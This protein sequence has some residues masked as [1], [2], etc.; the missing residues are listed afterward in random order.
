MNT[1]GSIFSTFSDEEINLVIQIS[2]VTAVVVCQFLLYLM[3]SMYPSGQSSPSALTPVNEVRNEEVPPLPTKTASTPLTSRSAP[4]TKKPR[5][6]RRC[7][8][9]DW[10][11]L[12]T[13]RIMWLPTDNNL[14]HK[15]SID[16]ISQIVNVPHSYH[17]E[18]LTS[19]N[20]IFS[21]NTVRLKLVHIDYIVR[22][23]WT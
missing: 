8:V 16:Q 21:I 17:L 10:W 19:S 20:Q 12:E 23:T 4:G 22:K 14:L 11:R 7:L 6:V 5:H 15:Y 9:F 2:F 1:L 18:F 3:Y 13:Q